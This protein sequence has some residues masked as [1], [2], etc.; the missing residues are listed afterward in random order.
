MG[1]SA[2]SLLHHCHAHKLWGLIN[3][4]YSF[5]NFVALLAIFYYRGA[6]FFNENDPKYYMVPFL[7]WVTVSAAELV[8]SFLWVL[9]EPFF[10][11]PVTRTVFPE[12]LP[13]DPDLPGIDVFVCTADP[14]KEPTFGVMNTVVS[15]MALDYPAEKLSVYLSDDGGASVTLMGMKEAW[16]FA[17]WWLP[18]C[19]R[20]N[21]K[22]ICP[23]SY[24]ERPEEESQNME[25]IEDRNT[26]KE[27]YE[28]FKQRVERKWRTELETD[29][30]RSAQN[31]PAI[32]QGYSI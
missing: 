29:T 5:L 11:F 7:P 22:P 6:F 30:K 20:W 21:V 16:A 8:S 23:Q 31:H 3:R 32:I 18:F 26:I 15:A 14:E 13:K 2:P 9:K 24:F 10:W 1:D 12:S 4:T 19:R 28:A 27:K 17:T 25:F